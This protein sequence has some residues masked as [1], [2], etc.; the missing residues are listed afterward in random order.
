[1]HP[2]DFK[3][4]EQAR[5]TINHWVADNTKDKIPEL[6]GR[7]TL[8]KDN[9]L[10][11]TNAVYFKG[12]WENPFDKKQ[13]RDE[14]FHVSGDKTTQAPLMR[15]HGRYRYFAGDGVQVVDLPY[16][17]ERIAM[18]VVLPTAGDGLPAV[19][20]KLTAQQ[21]AGWAG[22]LVSKPGEVILP[23]FQTT[24][25]FDLSETLQGMGMKRAFTDAADFGGMCSD[26]LKISKV[27]HKAF[28]ET[29]EEGSE[30]AAA[31]G[32]TMVAAAA[33]A[34]Q[35]PFTFRADHPFLFV[36]R[37]TK[38]NTPLFVGRIVNPMA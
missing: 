17:G 32:V 10:V 6:F 31:T 20:S 1:M 13:T 38:A 7:G 30:A 11:L 24:D 3:Q 5:Q 2:I 28:V 21:L 26:P 18:M 8:T 19:E 37:D 14:A 16:A 35:P 33:H 23:R 9:L 25:E 12:K 22:K 4:T 29:N 36:I 34:P 27:I 15:R